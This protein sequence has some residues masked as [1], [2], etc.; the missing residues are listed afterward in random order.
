MPIKTTCP[1]CDKAYTLADTMEGKS[2][3]CKGCGQP[4]KVQAAANGIAAKPSNG[5]AV[6]AAVKKRVADDD[7]EVP[8]K[9]KSG[10]GIFLMIGGGLVAVLMILVCGGVGIGGYLMYR[11]YSDSD[12]SSSTASMS[13]DKDKDKDRIENPRP[14]SRYRDYLGRLPT[15]AGG[16]T[17]RASGRHSRQ[18]VHENRCRR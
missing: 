15:T 6:K 14:R 5:K 3:K 9:K 13:S 17:V 16:M 12:D 11:S 10:V 18:A 1:E 2:V 8:V 4:Y 7:D